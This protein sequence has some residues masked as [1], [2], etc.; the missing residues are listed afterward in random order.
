MAETFNEPDYNPYGRLK[1]PGLNISLELLI[2][3]LYPSFLVPAVYLWHTYRQ[4]VKEAALRPAGCR[5]LGLRGSSHAADEYDSKYDNGT[6]DQSDWKIKALFIHP[7]KS[8]AAVELDELEIEDAGPAWDRRFCFAELLPPT[9]IK[10]DASEEEKKARWTFRTLRQPGYERLVFVKPEVWIPE[11]STQKDNSSSRRVERNGAL[12][13]RYP[14]IPSGPLAFL[15]RLMMS[16][17]MLPKENSFQVPLLPPKDRT[18]PKEQVKIWVDNPTWFNYGEHVPDDFRQ[19]LG[20]KNR[21]A[22]FRA[23]PDAYRE[24]YRCA[25]RKEEI[26]YQ[27]VVGCADAYPVNL[28][29]LA[30]IHDVGNRIKEAIPKFSSRRFRGNLLLTGPKAYDE[31]DWKRIRIHSRSGTDGGKDDAFDLYCACHCV[32]CRLP[33][34]DP[35]TAIRHPSEPD[36]TLRSF[37]CIDEGDP[38]G[39]CLGLQ[40]VPALSKGIT[41]KVGD[42]I[43]VLE[44]GQHFYLRQGVS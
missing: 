27:A 8:C 26:G 19:F 5:K 25:P 43:E 40:L 42:R 31:D 4:K 15:D 2:L 44:R 7:V 18:Y 34:V 3:V 6:D 36:K 38:H 14:N 11:A 35:D 13:I 1:V 12:I 30:S 21:I 22:L 16:W 23:D 41:L 17:N 24:V 39:A 20:A 9:V 33:N 37:R 28:L 29:N 32:R 10:S